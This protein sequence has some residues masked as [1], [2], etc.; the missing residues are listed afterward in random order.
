MCSE[1]WSVCTPSKVWMLLVSMRERNFALE[2]YLMKLEELMQIMSI[3]FTT[4]TKDLRDLDVHQMMGD[5]FCIGANEKCNN[6]SNIFSSVTENEGRFSWGR[7]NAFTLASIDHTSAWVGMAVKRSSVLQELKI[8]LEAVRIVGSLST[9]WA[10]CIVMTSL[11]YLYGMDGVSG[12]SQI[13]QFRWSGSR[14][15][16]LYYAST[17]CYSFHIEIL[18][19]HS[20]MRPTWPKGFL[21]DLDQLCLLARLRQRFS[22]SEMPFNGIESLSHQIHSVIWAF[23]TLVWLCTVSHSTHIIIP[24]TVSFWPVNDNPFRPSSM[25]AFCQLCYFFCPF[26]P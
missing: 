4:R 1:C 14:C 3:L 20:E 25:N 6:K 5:T 18:T 2:R 26:G 7:R 12:Q 21:N 16:E 23:C 13:R 17:C 19:L 11:V 22:A 15:F 8:D 24:R 9:F 10:K